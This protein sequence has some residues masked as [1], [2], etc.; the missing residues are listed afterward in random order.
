M[1]TPRTAPTSESGI[2]V[3]LH[4]IKTWREAA[5][6]RS[7]LSSKRDE[8]DDKSSRSMFS[9]VPERKSA[10]N[11]LVQD[12]RASARRGSYKGKKIGRWLRNLIK[13]KES[14]SSINNVYP[15][16]QD[17]C[18][19]ANALDEERLARM[20][21]YKERMH[22]PS[23][24]CSLDS[25]SSYKS[26]KGYKSFS[27]ELGHG[28]GISPPQPRAH[29]FD[30]LEELL[31]S[32]QIK[33]YEAKEVVDVELASFAADITNY[34]EQNNSSVTE[35]DMAK[36]LFI[37]AQQCIEM[38]YVEF[39]VKC[40]GIVQD[41]TEKRQLCQAVQL[42]WLFTHIIFILTRCT[43]LLLLEK[44]SESIDEKAFHKFR[45]CLESL[46]IIDRSWLPAPDISNSG[47]VHM[48]IQK[49]DV[50]SDMRQQNQISTF[51]QLC[52]LRFE[53][54]TV[55]KYITC[56]NDPVG[57]DQQPLAIE[58]RIDA[59]SQAAQFE[60][61][62]G[63][64]E[65]KSMN[66]PRYVPH[67]ELEE[68]SNES[69]DVICRICEQFVPASH[70]ESHSYICAHADK[71]DMPSFSVEE[72]LAKLAELLEQIIESRNEYLDTS[73]SS[74]ESSRMQPGNV[75]GAF[76]GC[77]PRVS[78]WQIKGVDGMFKDLHE[79][80]TASVDDSP[81]M[82]SMPLKGSL[83]W[84]FGSLGP[85]SSTGS[86]TSGS[87][88]NTPRAAHFDLFWLDH[89]NPSIV[90]DVHQLVCLEDI[91]RSVAAVD[92]SEEGSCEL[93]IARMQDLQEILQQK[94]PKALLVDTFGGRIE[95]LLQQKYILLCDLTGSTSQED[96]RFRERSPK[97]LP[98]GAYQSS[99]VS[100]PLH[101]STK[102]RTSIDDFEIIKPISRGA[103][104][105]VF[106]ARKRTT[107]DIF[108]IKVLKKLD[109]IRKN[110][111]EKILAE[112]N[113]LIA[114]R[115]PFVVRFY[116]S[117]TS[118][119]NLYLVMEYLNGGDIYSLLWNVGCLDENMARVYIAELVL[120]L[121]YLHSLGIV[122]RDLKPDNILIA[123]T[124]H[125]KL[126]DF[127]LSKIGLMN[128]TANL[129]VAEDEDDNS[130]DAEAWN[131][132]QIEDKCRQSAVGTPDYLAPEILLR[133]HHGYAADWWSVG[134]ILFELITGVPPFNAETP[135]IIFHNML[136]RKII[137]PPCGMSSEAQ[138][139]INRFLVLDPHHR[140][141]A[142]GA[143]EVKAHLFFKGI[144]WE[145]LASQKA[146]F[147]PQPEA[148]DDTSYFVSRCEK[149]FKSEDQIST[150]VSDASS[151]CS[152][153]D[154]EVD[155][156]GDLAEFCSSPL[157]PL[158]IKFSFK[159]LSQLASINHD[160]L[161]RSVKDSTE[162]LPPSQ[163]LN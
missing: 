74:P 130:L 141:G 136:N 61:L 139:L 72:R 154:A 84:K 70:L 4:R 148:L 77:S 10:Q 81:G 93:L 54:P 32:L 144:N 113:I 92:P 127:G 129:Y 114:A 51:P 112:R 142:N 147:V 7:R 155:G 124:G 33:F 2:P 131:A 71:C 106:L 12:K 18:S 120:A 161:L 99:T 126:T 158:L 105:R 87:S 125:I 138:D 13:G 25:P 11:V 109:M 53:K 103:F 52:S 123:H 104:G 86:M 135:E 6:G 80:D 156:C 50:K 91:A 79:M 35:H 137:W 15:K 152:D 95:N 58:G 128:N 64:S 65:V 107:G 150:D 22:S 44:D 30:D 31:G 76:A 45:K 28:S 78:E 118:R 121:E 94:K 110:D 47:I 115:N 101:P 26:S 5:S 59:F 48:A 29:S 49:S 62:E 108:A 14:S 63:G 85:P 55:E 96:D 9:P 163:A 27:H 3:G 134:I 100:T 90:E 160:V 69:N 46:P 56:R 75:E 1:A 146:A 41:L 24:L 36:E 21:T 159:N 37:L 40:E 83:A 82:A 162:S 23:Q 122:H 143:S 153:V 17:Y 39:R 119:D 117:F 66:S 60:Q 73:F 149:K 19:G 157:D 97:V 98:D 140:L 20:K 43:R 89:Y 88:T 67:H 42:K 38:S 16:N 116:Y 34:L 102:D 133:S 132:H 8:S 151:S 145:T 111:V 57:F 68:S